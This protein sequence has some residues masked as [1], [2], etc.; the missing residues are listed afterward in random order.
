[1]FPP[2]PFSPI[3]TSLY[4]PQELMGT[5]DPGDYQSFE[6][7][8]DFRCFAYY[9][10]H[11]RSAPRDPLAS[12]F[13]AL[14]DNST[15]QATL[16]LLKG[17]PRVA[18]IMGGH[19][20]P[21]GSDVYRGVARIAAALCREKFL[22]A[23]GGGPGAMEA[24]HLGAC[25]RDDPAA[26]ESAIEELK[27]TAPSLPADAGKVIGPNGEIDQR[28]V[29][30]LH[31]WT[32]PAFRLSQA[33]H[34]ESLALPTWY[35]GHEPST[36]FAIHIAKYFQNSIRED[37][38]I[39]LAAHG[40]VFASRKAG[41]LQE[42]F[43]DSVRNYYRSASDPFS[44]MVFFGKAYWTEKLPAAALLQALFRNAGRET[45]YT[46]NVLITDDENEAAAFLVRKAPPDNAH[47]ARLRAL[48]MMT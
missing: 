5:L 21:R 7:T 40:I 13:E 29:Q 43:Q 23:S 17:R 14:H 33:A 38:L 42:I 19:D 12:L 46:E 44:P 41:T 2:I 6:R 39:A 48:G 22:M 1:M 37:A 4:S 26:L 35:Y 15:T 18:A 16:A 32:M 30:E 9:A 11:G 36:P 45:E 24:A 31:A 20:E 25:F 47:L 34:G 10:E 8:V 3:R 27:H 28:I